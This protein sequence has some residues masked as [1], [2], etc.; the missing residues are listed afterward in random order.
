MIMTKIQGITKN[1]R[2]HTLELEHSKSTDNLFELMRLWTK[3]KT[4][5][6]TLKIQTIY[7]I[8]LFQI[9]ANLKSLTIKTYIKYSVYE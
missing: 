4:Y 7:D 8:I 2:F 5:L 6:M 3:T 9:T 1:T